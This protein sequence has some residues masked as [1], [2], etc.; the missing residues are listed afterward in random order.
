MK[1]Y[2]HNN[3]SYG[4]RFVE[5]EQVLTAI[6]QIKMAVGAGIAITK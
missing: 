2:H 5:G 4:E 6:P 1:E 3:V